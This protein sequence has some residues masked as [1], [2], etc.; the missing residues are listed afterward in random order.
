MAGLGYR[1]RPAVAC[2]A[3]WPERPCAPL[4]ACARTPPARSAGLGAPLR[5]LTWPGPVPPIKTPGLGHRASPDGSRNLEI[6]V[7]VGR[8]KKKS[9]D[10][11]TLKEYR[12][13]VKSMNKM[14][15]EERCRS[16]PIT[17]RRRA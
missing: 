10:L 11:G 7:H 15:R 14:N 9:A 1:I 16:V 8:S 12:Q 4:L 3:A 13:E 5:P 6:L 2:P 17:A